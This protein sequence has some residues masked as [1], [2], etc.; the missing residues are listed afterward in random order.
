M[1]FINNEK[2]DSQWILRKA[3]FIILALFFL[4][5]FESKPL[6]NLLASLA[7]LLSFFYIGF[8]DRKF[9]QSNPY[10]LLFIVPYV[11]GFLLGFLSE[12]GV[13]GALAFLLRFK[14]ML[15]VI[16]LAVFI[17]E[18]KDLHI[19]F[20]MFFA[21]ASIAIAYGI[22]T[23]Q[24]YGGFKGFH[25][26]GR[27]SDMMIVVCL[28]ALTFLMLGRF[29]SNIKPLLLKVL[30]MFIVVFSTWAVMMSEIRGAWL[31]LTIG[32]VL[33]LLLL[34][35]FQRK[36]IALNLS[37]LSLCVVS[38]IYLSDIGGI[39]SNINRINNQIESIVETNNNESNESRIDLWKAGWDFSKEHFV[40][41]T[42][43]KQSEAMFITFFY[44]QTPEYQKDHRFAINYPGEYHNSYM[45][46]HVETGIIFLIIFLSS[47]GYLLLMLLKNI[48]KIPF[49]DQKYL[50]ATIV[51][52]VAFMCAQ[53]F[54]S[55][56]Y[57]YGSTIFYL[58]LFS[59]CYILNQNNPSIWFHK[60]R[61]NAT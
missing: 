49:E 17:K 46:I 7:L 22:Y 57:H 39:K 35:M 31:G 36:L 11:V 43:A 60:G 61:K 9:L 18:R 28:T 41:G 32:S 42:G 29:S 37:I 38:V 21:S 33:F 52:S 27:T 19:L 53:V 8:Y 54:H 56:L 30:M 55:D 24:P 15:L 34:L 1:N 45:Q 13:T 20:I 51:T 25:K 16:P 44:E 48:N 50:I 10:L 2:K 40:F 59:G 14:F 5:V 23:G 4:I 12:S 47:I 3:G 58:L 6:M 26:I